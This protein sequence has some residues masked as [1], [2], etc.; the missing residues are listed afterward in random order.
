MMVRWMRW[1]CS[2]DTEFEIRVLAFWGRARY[3]SV[4]EAPHNIE[5]LRVSRE[6]T[7]CF[8]ETWRP[9]CGSNPRSSTFKQAA[10][11]TALGP[12]PLPMGFIRAICHFTDSPLIL[13]TGKLISRKSV[14]NQ[15]PSVGPF[16]EMR[17]VW[18]V[19]GGER[20]GGEGLDSSPHTTT[21]SNVE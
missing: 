5:S 12:P 16:E 6:E 4:T 8:F 7:F 20:G 21:E 14:S 18:C 10:L 17:H 13:Q 15:T 3:L 9:E 11:T 1:H 19:F 2:P